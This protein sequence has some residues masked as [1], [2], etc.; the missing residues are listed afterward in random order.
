AAIDRIVDMIRT[1]TNVTGDM[2]TAVVI[3]KLENELDVSQFN[4][5]I[6]E[7]SA[8]ITPIK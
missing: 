3:G 6:A 7:D 4:A 1:A 2:M 8:P 5:N